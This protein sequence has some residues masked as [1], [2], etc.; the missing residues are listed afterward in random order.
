MT[1]L[2]KQF[3]EALSKDR[4]ESAAMLEK[5]SMRGVKNS[6]VDKYSDQAHF[7]YELLQNADDAGA[8]TA[9]FV[10]KKDCLIF[11]HNGTRH[12]SVSN[13]A[14][15]DNDS[16]AGVL[17]D[18]NAIISIAH[19]NK[20]EVEAS[21]GKFGVGF[22]A[23]FQ[24]TSTPH[25][26]DPNF[27]F[28]IDRFIVP[29]LLKE[30]YPE[31]RENETLFVLPFDHPKTTANMA[32]ADIA[33]KLKSLTYP[34]LFLNCLRDIEYEFDGLIGLYGKVIT[35]SAHFGRD[36]IDKV[37]LTQNN[38]DE[39][40]DELLWLF[41]REDE[42]GL[43]YSVGFFVDKDGHLR[44]VS[45]PA[46]CFFPTKEVTGLNFIV[47]APFL[48]TDSREGIRTGVPHNDRMVQLLAQLAADALLRLKNIGVRTSTRI[49]DDGILSIAPVDKKKFNAADNNRK[50][51]F[52][53]FYNTIKQAF[54][55]EEILPSKDGYTTAKNAYW[56]AV[57]QLTQLF[58]DEQLGAICGNDKAKWVFVSLGRDEIRRN[59]ES[60]FD[61]IEEITRTS[62]NEDVLINGRSKSTFWN[63]ALSCTQTTESIIGITASFIEAQPIRWLHE[64]YKW[65]SET[66]HRTDLITDR[67]VFLDTA[68]NAVA[69]FDKNGE[70]ILFLPIEATQKYTTIHPQLLENASTREFI[71]QVGI[72]KPS[73]RSQIYT[74]ILPLYK[75]NIN[76][77]ENSVSLDVNSHFMLFF[78]YYCEC[79]NEEVDDFLEDIKECD[80]I[81]CNEAT[82]TREYRAKAD[83]TYYPTPEL[84]KYFSA[85]PDTKFVAID[86]YKGMVDSSGEKRLISFLNELGV[87]SEPRR[88]Q[89]SDGNYNHRESEWVIDGLSEIIQEIIQTK[90]VQRSSFLWNILCKLVTDNRL[91]ADALTKTIS[92]RP[93]GRYRFRTTYE[94]SATS[95]A[96]K[97]PWLVNN[98]GDFV[99]A[100]EVSINALSAT[101]MTGA[102]GAA[103]LA[104][105]L[106]IGQ[107]VVKNNHR[108]D[109]HL[110]QEQREQIEFAEKCNKFGITDADISEL[111]EIRQRRINA[112]KAEAH[113]EQLNSDALHSTNPDLEATA[114]AATDAERILTDAGERIPA[115]FSNTTSRVVK[116]IISRAQKMPSEKVAHSI[117]LLDCDDADKDEFMPSPVDYT[118]KIER[119]KQK[120]A[121]EIDRIAYYEDL[122]QTAMEAPRYSFLWFKT[123]LEME[124]LNSGESNADS[125]EVSIS[126]ARVEHEQGTQR[127]LVLKQP[128]R[129]IPQ[130]MEDLADIPLVLHM[131]EQTK[132]VAIEVA[133]I[134]SYTLRVK[135]KSNA[136]IEGINLAEVTEATIEAQSPV[137]LLDALKKQ[138]SA[139]ELPDDYDMQANL[140]ENIEFVFGPPGTGKTTYLAGNVLLP[141]MRR[142]ENLKVL[143][144]TPT[145]KAADV[146]V[147]RIMEVAG[148]DT[149]YNDWLVRFGTTNDEI[150]EQSQ[151]YRDKTFDIRSLSRS[152][153][154]TTIARFPYDYFMPQGAR[155]FL[156]GINWDYIVIDE[157]SMIPLVNIIYPLYK[158]TPA[159]FIIAGDPFQIEPITSV[160]LW[161]NENIYTLVHLD[162]FVEPK[163]IPHQYDVKLLTT[164]Y[165]SI[166][167]IGEVF[168]NFAYG[169]ILQHHRTAESQRPLNLD[170]SMDIETLNII[171][172]PVSKYESIY[173]SKRLQHSSSYQIYSALFTYEYV[174]YLARKIAEAN[175]NST[176]RI[177]IIAPYRA[178]ADLIDKLLSSEKLPKEVDVQVGTIH[179][180]QGDECDIIFAVFNT[181]PS[182]SSSKE[183]FLNKKNIINVSISRA[184]DYLFVVMPDDDT[185]NV[186]N[187]RLVKRVE[188]LVKASDCWNETASQTLEQAVFGNPHYLED[189]AFS[190][191]HQSVNVYGLPERCYEIRTE[192]TAVDVQV[193][194]GAK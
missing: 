109:S 82:T 169:G 30:D 192:D 190:T 53:P 160:D 159:K 7:I 98:C 113:T 133:N 101:C 81:I 166:P 22:K 147:N 176:F 16:S 139:L 57:P 114:A 191:S 173:R 145:N 183:M 83:T 64:F 137:F 167:A 127:T 51:S 19:S 99:S 4:A 130:F 95:C 131:G 193:H 187:L 80:F 132:K 58:S 18:I 181:P 9:R 168:S 73:L 77:E 104:Q 189:N 24:Y 63:R 54:L 37:C 67:R 155:V 15:E 134:K 165:R 34:L 26:Y 119:E 32:Y 186:S 33:G 107:D 178:Q 111:I 52:S 71:E 89:K 29:V 8:T 59:Q 61:Y 129:Y 62:L 142:E 79:P 185:E 180:F 10:L 154:V 118:K 171:K 56:A 115:D 136:E 124:V 87:E 90:D 35:E 144:L 100:S 158:K 55:N 48:L 43:K 184:K 97:L 128:N 94:T 126:F 1:E 50:I 108:D 49:I 72:K 65:L 39:I 170:S 120:S 110:S 163:T 122:Q 21:I 175:K 174:S 138:F 182:I 66:K 76:Q 188:N 153:T 23:V 151:V 140:C 25:I 68:G 116:D 150:I 148:T 156:Q 93:D 149:A 135:L 88:L 40:Y 121:A 86:K 91:D 17:G 46:F 177:G 69:A 106:G 179:G 38:G 31:R 157:A 172:F 85:K 78:K 6:V 96:L 44:P 84:L 2:E 5:P 27:K 164:Q 28:R 143:V 3:F 112:V 11:A 60:L 162:S 20:V 12:F 36:A 14:T 75:K 125:K 141:F 123:L 102:K 70:E 152:V 103:E 42:N 194:K 117:E 105:L 161:K 74:V 47:H 41:S 13:P 45:E 92:S 146:L